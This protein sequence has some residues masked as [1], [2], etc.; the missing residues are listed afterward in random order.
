MT[1]NSLQLNDSIPFSGLG[2]A[3]Y[4][5]VTT[6]LYTVGF[7]STIPYVSAGSA[8]N[9]TATAPSALSVVVN[10]DT[11]GGPVAKLTVTS[12]GAFQRMVGGSARIQCTADDVLTVVLT[13][14]NA[15]DAVLNAVKTT[16]N[17]CGG[18]T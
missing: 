11:G 10:Q 7:T 1:T 17:L 14:A 2:T 15:A 16:I 4:T 8:S 6:G 9:S 5:V 3:T 18:L 12:P 13:S